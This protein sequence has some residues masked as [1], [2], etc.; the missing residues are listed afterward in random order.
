MIQ[1]AAEGE[2]RQTFCV[3]YVAV[4]VGLIVMRYSTSSTQKVPLASSICHYAAP[5]YRMVSAAAAAV[6]DDVIVVVMV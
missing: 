2:G 5:C 6:V 3:S 4:N 1:L